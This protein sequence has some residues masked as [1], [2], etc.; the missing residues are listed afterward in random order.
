LLHKLSSSTIAKS[1]NQVA[2]NI[3]SNIEH[4]DLLS[5]VQIQD[6]MSFSYSLEERDILYGY[7]ADVNECFFCTRANNAIKTKKTNRGM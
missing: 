4:P 7:C 2:I 3:I 6:K 5:T 1:H